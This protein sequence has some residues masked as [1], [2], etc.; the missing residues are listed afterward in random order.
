MLTYREI[1]DICRA[2]NSAFELVQKDIVD[3]RN[4]LKQFIYEVKLSL[5]KKIIIWYELGIS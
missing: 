2:A 5:N 1:P 3:I 4:Y